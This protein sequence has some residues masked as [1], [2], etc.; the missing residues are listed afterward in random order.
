MTEE[1]KAA[2]V[3]SQTACAMIEALG[4]FAMN[5]AEVVRAM[6]APTQGLAGYNRFAEILDKYGIHHTSVM[7]WFHG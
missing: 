7:T 6:G 3:A 5:Q 1:Q 4:V 2:Y